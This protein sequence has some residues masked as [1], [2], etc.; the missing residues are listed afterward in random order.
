MRYDLMVLLAFLVFGSGACIQRGTLRTATLPSAS[1]WN[2]GSYL[3]THDVPTPQLIQVAVDITAGRIVNIR[4]LEHPAWRAPEAQ[5]ELLR[6]V[7]T[8]QT[9]EGHVP[10]GTG[11]EEDR[12]L[13]AIDE[14][15]IKAQPPFP[16]VP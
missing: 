5:D 11:S 9:T 13:R 1:L 8:S 2:D 14:A 4:L 15:L 10:R 3:G 12:L 16:A 6:L 7:M